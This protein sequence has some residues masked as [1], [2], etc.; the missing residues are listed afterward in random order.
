[1]SN[2]HP[3]K[4]ASL[5]WLLIIAVLFLVLLFVYSQVYYLYASSDQVEITFCDVGQ[6]DGIL[7]DFGAGKQAVVDGGPNES[8]LACLGKNLPITDRKIEYLVLTHPDADHLRGLSY[9]IDEYQV[10][11]LYWTKVNHNSELYKNFK[12]KV[13]DKNIVQEI[14]DSGDIINEGIAKLDFI[15]PVN[16]VAGQD[17]SNLNNSSAVSVLDIGEIEIFLTG[18][19]ETEVFDRLKQKLKRMEVLKVSHHGAENGTNQKLLDIIRPEAAVISAGK[20]NQYG[21]PKKEVVDLLNEF[22]ID[23]YRTDERGDIKLISD[24]S[25]YQI[26]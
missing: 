15:Y 10:G 14:I 4:K 6:G 16:S 8:I 22:K 9:I 1:M 2:N 18:D 24:G 23:I 25:S 11:K 5:F 13:K 21:H 17:F 12:K 19:A 20:D 26:N 7:I 3:S